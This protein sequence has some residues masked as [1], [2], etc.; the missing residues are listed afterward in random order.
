MK[1]LSTQSFEILNESSVLDYFQAEIFAYTNI[2]LFRDKIIKILCINKNC[3][4]IYIKNKLKYFIK[5]G[6]KE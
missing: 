6:K 4:M 5:H 1:I 2:K 3:F